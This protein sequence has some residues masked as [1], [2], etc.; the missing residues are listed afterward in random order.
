[1]CS[2]LWLRSN[3]SSGFRFSLRLIV[4]SYSLTRPAIARPIRPDPLSGVGDALRLPN[5]IFY[6]A[7]PK[8]SPTSLSLTLAPRLSHYAHAVLA[9]RTEGSSP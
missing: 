8:R 4:Q 5:A 6:C 1:M 3:L 9:S 7:F 2:L